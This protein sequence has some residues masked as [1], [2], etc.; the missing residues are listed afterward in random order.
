MELGEL[1]A[2]L[3]YGK[4][5]SEV[6]WFPE[7]R[8]MLE[9]LNLHGDV[10]LVRGSKAFFIKD[11][12]KAEKF[13]ERYG[14]EGEEFHSRLAS[15]GKFSDYL[16]AE[17]PSFHLGVFYINS[18]TSGIVPFDAAGTREQ[19]QDLKKR[20]EFKKQ[21]LDKLRW[22]QGAGLPTGREAVSVE[23]EVQR[24]K[25]E[26]RRL[27]EEEKTSEKLRKEY[28]KRGAGAVFVIRTQTAPYICREGE[29][30]Q[31]AHE[32]L[33]VL[34][35]KKR[36]IKQEA[37]QGFALVIE[38]LENPALAFSSESMGLFDPRSLEI[39]IEK[40][41]FA[42][43]EEL[44]GEVEKLFVHRWAKETRVGEKTY[45]KSS[46]IAQGIASLLRRG[47]PKRI[48]KA[49]IPQ[50]DF[51]KLPSFRDKGKSLTYMGLILGDDFESTGIPYLYDLN[52][53]APLHTLIAGATGSGKTITAYSLAEGALM[54]NIPVLVLDTTGQ[55]TGFLRPCG[56]GKLLKLYKDF[57]MDVE[58]AGFR[59]RVYT[60]SSD[61]GINLETNLLARPEV[62]SREELIQC[63]NETSSVIEL[64]CNL[65]KKETM[66]VN[67]VILDSWTEKQDLDHTNIIE[68]LE[69]WGKK[70]KESVFNTKLKLKALGG[71]GFLFSGSGL[72]D[73]TALWKSGE[74][75][76]IDISH[77]AESQKLY[78]QYFLMREL[79]SYFYTQPDSDKLKLLLVVEEVHRFLPKFT[80][81]APWEITIFL[82]RVIRELRK[83]GVGAIFIS[84]VLTDFRASIRGNTATKILMRTSYDGDIDRATK[85]MG[86]AYSKHLNKL[87]TGQGVVSFA[88]FGK[89][90]FVRFRPPLHSPK[91]MT[92]E[93]IS[94]EMEPYKTGEKIKEMLRPPKIEEREI[95]E[96]PEVVGKKLG[97]SDEELFL[98]KI[99]EFK[100]DH[101]TPPRIIDIK[102]QLGWGDK[103]TT[104]V[105]KTL[106]KSGKVKKVEDERDRRAKR[107]VIM[108]D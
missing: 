83:K 37:W 31:M 6:R 5:K 100:N 78:C 81:D 92:S 59:G 102:Q 47:V 15:V 16:K 8:S 45:E 87:K 25:E 12:Y 38:E 3:N 94:K 48:A 86:R 24:L 46:A 77:L 52:T 71:Y 42:E 1:I 40:H 97:L 29:L 90:F 84:Q 70:N 50:P 14:F 85:D 18:L 13:Q 35:N 2:T 17:Q 9:I 23:A 74:I 34:E 67:S 26:L 19:I 88:D 32:V 21:R 73:I 22:E 53:Q 62:E 82:D 96:P 51:K 75:T 57:D 10:Y 105:V 44:K 41:G 101:G 89:P 66:H 108:G 80:K 68:K 104:D 107:L 49:K 4:V 99:K 54:Q 76:I 61:I 65:S 60:P 95:E 20:V 55:W 11:I 91:G 93:E 98:Q 28:E 79:L 63:A 64:I 103:K 7:Q 30:E 43:L 33:E 39:L 36:I 58:P 27:E 106:E 69:E 56:D 72:K